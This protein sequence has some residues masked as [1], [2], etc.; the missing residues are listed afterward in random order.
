MVWTGTIVLLY[1]LFH[2]ADSSTWGWWLGDDF[3]RGDVYHNLTESL[4]NPVVAAIYIVANLALA[5]H[6]Y[7]GTNSLFQSLGVNS[8]R[9]NALRR[10]LGLGIAL[11]VG[12]GNL[13]FRSSPK[14]GY[15]TDALAARRSRSRGSARGRSGTT[16]A[17]R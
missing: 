11:F 13:S 16:T 5:I 14:Q 6:L 10:P 15:S 2:L 4:S 7:H 3:V 17:S 8:P 1:V 9:I 12:V